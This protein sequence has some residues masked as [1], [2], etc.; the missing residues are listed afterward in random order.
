VFNVRP[1]FTRAGWYKWMVVGLLWV[2]GFFNA[3]DRHSIYSLFPVFEKEL[4]AS[5]LELGLLGSGFL[6]AYAMLGPFAGYIGDRF[7]RRKV[8][9]ISVLCWSLTTALSGFSNSTNMLIALRVLL[10]VCEAF[11]LPTALAM[12]SD[13]HSEATRSKAVALQISAMAIGQ[14]TGG[15][16]GGF[17]GERFGWRLV[18]FGLGGAGLLWV[19]VLAAALYGPSKSL[20]GKAEVKLQKPLLMAVADLVRISSLRLLVIAFVCYSMVGAIISTWLPYYLFKAFRL[21]LTAA[22]FS[23]NFYLEVPTSVGNLAGGAVGD[24]FAARNFRGR[25]LTQAGS[26]ILSAPFFV[27]LATAGDFKQVAGGLILLGFIR[28]AWASNVMPVICQIVPE[29]LRATTYGIMNCLGNVSGGVAAI[30]ASRAVGTR[31]G[32]GTAFASCGLLYWIAAGVLILAAWTYLK[33]DFR[34]QAANSIELVEQRGDT[35]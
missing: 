11:Y 25:M 13:H 27:V 3:V 28:G 5:Q 1:P 33:R 19:P 4:G 35:K 14:V 23:A 30:I 7:P 17:I 6:W 26:L 34:V 21:S 18:F 2:A 16:L 24:Y 10:A 32:M 20:A 8:I 9:I 29:N 31:L 15:F 22:G 12:L